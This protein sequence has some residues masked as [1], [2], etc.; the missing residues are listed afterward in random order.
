MFWRKLWFERLAPLGMGLVALA[1]VVVWREAI[2]ARFAPN[3]WQPSNLYNAVFNWA[4]IQSGFVFG[5]Y[6]FVASKRDGFVGEIA[7]GRAFAQLL[8]YARRAYITGFVLTFVSLPVMVAAPS[9]ADSKSLSYW[10]V[11]VWFAAFVWTFCAF[12]RV[13]FTFGLIA[14]TPDRKERIVG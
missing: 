8:T 9:L 12:L 13:A 2:A 4:S 11:A 6:G 7:G 5:I 3:G 14:A 10:L 1:V